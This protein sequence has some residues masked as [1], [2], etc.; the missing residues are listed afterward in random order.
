MVGEVHPKEIAAV[1]KV[2]ENIEKIVYE[3]AM[4]QSDLE[5]IH[6]EVVN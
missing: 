5:A 3:P 1:K 6:Q 2:I 4:G